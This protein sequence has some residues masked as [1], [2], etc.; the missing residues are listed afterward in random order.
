MKKSMAVIM[1]G[2]VCLAALSGCTATLVENLDPAYQKAKK[3]VESAP[4]Y[5]NTEEAKKLKVPEMWKDEAMEKKVL[6]EGFMVQAPN[7]SEK[8]MRIAYIPKKYKQDKQPDMFNI[9]VVKPEKNGLDAKWSLIWFDWK[10]NP[11]DLKGSVSSFE[12]AKIPVGDTTVAGIGLQ[13]ALPS[14]VQKT[15]MGN[16]NETVFCRSIVEQKDIPSGVSNR[17][18]MSIDNSMNPVT[19]VLSVAALAL[20]IV[21]GIAAPAIAGIGS[22]A[23]A[24]GYGTAAVAGQAA[25]GVAGSLDKAGVLEGKSSA[26]GVPHELP[27]C[28]SFIPKEESK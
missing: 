10:D 25:A 23:T 5:V 27:A 15:F 20:P 26:S 21:G 18:G 9:I 1:I 22:A 16:E 14:F 6:F 2:M 4:S 28:V 7:G 19:T 8:R 3:A 24:F 11:E 13:K 17:L 12:G